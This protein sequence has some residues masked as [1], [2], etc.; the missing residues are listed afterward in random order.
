[1]NLSQPTQ[2]TQPEQLVGRTIAAVTVTQMIGQN[3]FKDTITWATTR[4]DFTDGTF[5]SFA[6]ADGEVYDAREVTEQDRIDLGWTEPASHPAHTECEDGCGLAVTHD[7]ACL[8]KPGGR[9]LCDHEATCADCGDPVEL[10]DP[11][12]PDSWTHVFGPPDDGHS[13]NTPIVHTATEA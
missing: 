7:G 5:I 8:D 9:V 3:T 11:T 10:Y 1:M 13:A 2:P 4:L 12:D 6:D